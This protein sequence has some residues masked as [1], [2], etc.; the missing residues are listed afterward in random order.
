MNTSY[1]SPEFDFRTV[2]NTIEADRILVTVEHDLKN[3]IYTLDFDYQRAEAD[4]QSILSG[5]MINAF[6]LRWEYDNI[7]IPSSRYG[8]IMEEQLPSVVEELK[9]DQNSNYGSVVF[10]DGKDT[11][12]CALTADFKIRH[13]V[14]NAVFFQRSTYKKQLPYDLYNFTGITR[15]VCERLEN[16]ELGMLVLVT[17]SLFQY[18]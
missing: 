2:S 3:P 16:I 6:R 11:L 17:T 10:W 14:L 5:K 18:A 8:F 7:R 9:R 15:W 12:P 1:S 4:L 13:G